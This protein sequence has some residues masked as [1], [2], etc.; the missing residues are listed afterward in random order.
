MCHVPGGSILAIRDTRWGASMGSEEEALVQFPM[1][2]HPFEGLYKGG[3]MRVYHAKVACSTFHL[4]TT[5]LLSVGL[6]CVK[7]MVIESGWLALH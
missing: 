7:G 1:S 6:L 3:V 2:M 4:P 5:W